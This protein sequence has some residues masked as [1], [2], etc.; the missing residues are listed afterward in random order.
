MRRG[1]VVGCNEGKAPAKELVRSCV[2]EKGL[3]FGYCRGCDLFCGYLVA[4]TTQWC[5]CKY[6]LAHDRVS[7]I[8]RYFLMVQTDPISAYTGKSISTYLLGRYSVMDILSCTHL[9]GRVPTIE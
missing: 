9:N 6:C 3:E 2:G 4:C 1:T 7:T 5:I 8:D